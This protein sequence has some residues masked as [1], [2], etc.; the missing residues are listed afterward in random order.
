MRKLLS[1]KC[2]SLEEISSLSPVPIHED[3]GAQAYAMFKNLYRPTD[4]LWIQAGHLSRDQ[5]Q[6]P[7]GPKSVVTQ[8]ELLRRIET[9]VIWKDLNLWGGYFGIN[10]V[11]GEEG[12]GKNGRHTDDD[13]SRFEYALLEHDELTIDEQAG[14]FSVLRLPIVSLVHSA[15]K[16]V[17]AMVRIGAPTFDAYTE[18]VAQ[19]YAGAALLGFDTSNKNPSR[20]S[21][22]PG[23]ARLVKG[24]GTELQRL[25]YLNPKATHQPILK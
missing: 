19:L 12:S 22:F 20:L 14:L 5:K 16:S 23:P 2:P 8:L 25:L 1:A 17:H 15:G 4:L 9:G 21:R 10:P 11:T 13:V 7:V 18:K 24:G 3:V 6:A